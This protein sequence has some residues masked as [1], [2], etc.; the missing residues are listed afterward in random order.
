MDAPSAEHSDHA[1]TRVRSHRDDIVANIEELGRM[2]DSL[3]E[4]LAEH[5]R[6]GSELTTAK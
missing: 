1:W 3:N 4:M 5:E 6:R 2:R